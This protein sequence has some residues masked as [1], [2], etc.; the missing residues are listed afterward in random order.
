MKKMCNC[1]RDLEGNKASKARSNIVCYNDIKQ[2]IMSC[3][4]RIEQYKS[5][6]FCPLNMA[7]SIGGCNEKIIVMSI[8]KTMI[9]LLI[10]F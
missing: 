9:K 2:F 7:L 5:S 4:V 3:R 1:A 6:S 10:F 8:K